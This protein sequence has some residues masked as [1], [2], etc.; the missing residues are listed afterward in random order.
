MTIINEGREAYLLGTDARD[1]PYTD[2]ERR[3]LWVTGWSHAKM[4]TQNGGNV[5]VVTES[6]QA[7]YL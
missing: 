1:V 3:I 2:I 5:N 4:E 7:I 6:A